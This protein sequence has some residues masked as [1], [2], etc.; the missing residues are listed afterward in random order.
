V[1]KADGAMDEVILSVGG[2]LGIA[3]KYVAVPYSD[4]KITHDGKTLKILTKGTKESLKAL[5]DYEYMK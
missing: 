1:I 4:L 2:F 3:S 5:P